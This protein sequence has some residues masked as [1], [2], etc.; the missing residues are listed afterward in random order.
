MAGVINIITKRGAKGLHGSAEAAVGCKG[1]RRGGL[2]L[3]NGNELG[4][5]SFGYTG[6]RFDG[7]SV[8]AEEL[9][10]TEEDG[11]ENHNFSGRVGLNFLEDGRADFFLNY[12]EDTA[13]LDGFVWP[14]PADDP[15]HERERESASG[16]IELSKPILDWYTQTLSASFAS[17]RIVGLDPDTADNRY[18]ISSESGAFSAKA[19]FFPF[20]GDTLSVSYDFERQRGENPD[21]NID[22]SVNVHSFLIQNHWTFEDMASLT[23]GV[24]HDDHETFGHEWTFRLA[25]SVE[26]PD[27]GTRFHGSL[28]TGFRA[29]TL[30][31]LYWPNTGWAM[32]NPNL[33]A[34]TSLGGDIG[35]EQSLFDDKIVADVTYFHSEIED[36]IQWAATGPNWWD[37]FMPQNVAEAKIDG[38]EATVTV[39]PIAD[40]DL[41]FGYAFTDHEDTTTGTELARRPRHRYSAS[42]NYRFIE[43]ANVN[44]SVIRVGRRFDDAAN[45]VELAPYT[46][47]D[48]AASY[49]VTDY[50]Q[51]FGRVEN[52]FDEDYEEA[53]GFDVAGRYGFAGLK[54]SF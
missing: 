28:G 30:N 13:D 17:D 33:K 11:W 23:A 39:R 51:V 44:V 48:V 26:I 47:V 5:F 12:S 15:N 50:V 54:L 38:V 29:P 21:N 2:S 18:D 37:P 7:G 9:G 45:A 31:D 36:L 1:Y 43:K 22:E 41:Q 16:K 34:E 27:M 32:G 14:N 53:R 25:G 46:R 3:S 40:L 49:D 6:T 10:N 24:R 19:D 8:A 4:D 35:I 52:V 42:A 20:A